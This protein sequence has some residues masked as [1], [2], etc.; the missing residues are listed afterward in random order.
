[1]FTG[2]TGHAPTELFLDWERA[3]SGRLARGIA[4]AP[5]IRVSARILRGEALGATLK[6]G[7]V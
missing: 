3:L 4:I 5:G 1:M 2:F 6:L 7:E